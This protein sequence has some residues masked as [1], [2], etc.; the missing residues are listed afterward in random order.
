M[1]NPHPRV[2]WFSYDQKANNGLGPYPVGDGLLKRRTVVS[3]GTA[4]VA[5]SCVKIEIIP[6][7]SVKFRRSIPVENY[8]APFFH[9]H[10]TAS[11]SLRLQRRLLLSGRSSLCL[12][13]RGKALVESV[14]IDELLCVLDL[15][16]PACVFFDV[17]IDEGFVGNDGPRFQRHIAGNLWSTSMN[18]RTHGIDLQA[19]ETNVNNDFPRRIREG[20]DGRLHEAFSGSGRNSATMALR[21]RLAIS[22]FAQF[23]RIFP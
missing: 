11:L 16:I 10:R 2:R 12:D 1:D 18:D 21:E 17:A 19:C 6:R 15:H 13:K 14:R 23:S 5:A 3:P 8:R 7:G 20:R 4:P 9:S 22:T